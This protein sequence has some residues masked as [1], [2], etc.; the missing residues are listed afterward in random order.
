MV[1]YSYKIVE[2]YVFTCFKCETTNL[3][4]IHN[5]IHTGDTEFWSAI[6]HTL[7]E[8][9]LKLKC[10]KTDTSYMNFYIA[11]EEYGLIWNIFIRCIYVFINVRQA[12]YMP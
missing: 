5:I 10:L 3:V 2:L 12:V 4:Y 11:T 7:Y 9:Q 8:A 1:Q 6:T